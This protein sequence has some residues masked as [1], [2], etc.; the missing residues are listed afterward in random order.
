MKA[1]ILFIT[2][3]MLYTNRF[4]RAADAPDC[5]PGMDNVG[6]GYDAVKQTPTVRLFEFDCK[7]ADSTVVNIPQ[8]NNKAFTVPELVTPNVDGPEL[9]FSEVSNEQICYSYEELYRRSCESFNLDVGYTGKNLTIGLFWDKIG[10]KFYYQLNEHGIAVS[11][12]Q[13]WKGMYQITMGPPFLLLEDLAPVP[14]FA[15][16]KLGRIGVPKTEVEHKQYV[17]TMSGC[18]THI[19]TSALMGGTFTVYQGTNSS[20]FKEYSNSTMSNQF[21][22]GFKYNKLKAQIKSGSSKV[23]NEM[24]EDVAKATNAIVRTNPD[25]HTTDIPKNTSQYEHWSDLVN[26]EPVMVNGSFLLLSEIFSDYPLVQQHMEKTIRFYLRT[27][28]NPTLH[29]LQKGIKQTKV[30][31]LDG[32]K[33]EKSIT[34]KLWNKFQQLFKLY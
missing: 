11:K 12:G 4:V 17:D 16:K 5:I 27:G 20:V 23:E 26:T 30:P 34:T 25:F 3:C 7:A 19:T 31:T 21:S 28:K 22:L 29:D 13:I 32:L 2:F 14:K 18:G 33:E 6:V 24:K 9:G 15:I 10:R 8:M 1:N